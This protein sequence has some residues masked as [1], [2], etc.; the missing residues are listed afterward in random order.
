[1][2]AAIDAFTWVA[3]VISFIG[4]VFAIGFTRRHEAEHRRLSRQSE[5]AAP[6]EKPLV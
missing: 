6:P 2:T 3:L 4:L 5:D 1:M